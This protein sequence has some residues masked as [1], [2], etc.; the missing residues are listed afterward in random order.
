MSQW[1]DKNWVVLFSSAPSCHKPCGELCTPLSFP[2]ETVGWLVRI[3]WMIYG[4]TSPNYS[5]SRSRLF[6]Q[7]AGCVV[8]MPPH[9]WAYCAHS[10]SCLTLD[11][12][13]TVGISWLFNSSPA[14][15]KHTSKFV[16]LAGTRFQLAKTQPSAKRRDSLTARRCAWLS[17]LSTLSARC[18][19]QNSSMCSLQWLTE[20]AAVKNIQLSRH[21]WRNSPPWVRWVKYARDSWAPYSGTIC[22]G[23][24]VG[25][26]LKQ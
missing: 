6:S 2:Y 9:T 14:I 12:P 25:F 3:L 5:T 17:R 19:M 21:V 4:K 8:S 24:E 7:R 1:H 13:H 20:Y 11:C 15:R 26:I 18:F 16:E 10:V 22:G 23:E